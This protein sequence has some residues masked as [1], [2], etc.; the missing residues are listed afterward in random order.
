MSRLIDYDPLT[1][2]SVSF[3]YNHDD[4]TFTI[5]HHE[6]VEPVLEDNKWA[7]LDLDMHKKQ[8]SAGW[9]HYAK[10][11]EIAILDMKARFGVDFFNADHWQKVMSLLN[12]EYKL[13]K[14]TTY[15]HDR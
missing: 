15:S 12:T 6:D 13:C 8:A 10:V 5:G 9:A 14:R 11:P 7:V 2:R 4:N 3:S 1:G